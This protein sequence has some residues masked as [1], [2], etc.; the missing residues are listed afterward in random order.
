[1]WTPAAIRSAARPARRFAGM[2]T[3]APFQG[4]RACP[5]KAAT[6]SGPK[7][8]DIGPMG[9]VSGLTALGSTPAA[10]ENAPSAMTAALF[11]AWIVAEPRALT[12]SEGRA[13][14]K[15]CAGIPAAAA[16]FVAEKVFMVEA[17]P[18]A[19]VVF[20]AADAYSGAKEGEEA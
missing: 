11:E 17:A 4:T 3:E 13:A 2:K 20:T 18:A 6:C 12:R 8:G 9:Q 7:L 15:S 5:D 14:T 19:A 10:G 1:M 16:V